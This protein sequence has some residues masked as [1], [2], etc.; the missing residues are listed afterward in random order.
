MSTSALGDTE[1]EGYRDHSEQVRRRIYST[2]GYRFSGGTT[3]RFDFGFVRNEGEPA[4]R[5]DAPGIR[6]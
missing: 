6:R 2:F 3:I 4:R 5:A 1:L